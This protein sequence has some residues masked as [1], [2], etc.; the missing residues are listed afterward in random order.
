MVNI[1]YSS[2]YPV[3]LD[4][5]DYLS[6]LQ[7]SILRSKLT[8]KI[9]NIEDFIHTN[10]DLKYIIDLALKQI[11]D[12]KKVNKIMDKLSI[13]SHICIVSDFDTDGVSSAVTLEEC[14]TLLGYTNLS[15]V[16]NKRIYGTGVTTYCLDKIEE[17]NKTQPIDLIILSDHGSA[18]E[19]EYKIIKSTYKNIKIIL[20]DHHTIKQDN[21]PHSVDAFINPQ[22][23]KTDSLLKDLSGCAVAYL[24]MLVIAKDRY[25]IL[26]DT[27]YLVGLSTI[28]DIMPMDNII[29]RYF[30]KIGLNLLY[31]K[32]NSLLTK[33]LTSD[34]V[35][36][37]DL[38]FKVI[39]VINTGNRT[40]TEELSYNYLKGDE[41]SIASLEILNLERKKITSDICRN[42]EEE[43]RLNKPDKSICTIIDAEYSIA[44]NIAGKLGEQYNLPTIIF[45]QPNDEIITGSIRGILPMINVV[46]ILDDIK[47]QDDSILIRYGGHKSAG[48]CSIHYKKY[49]KFRDLFNSIVKSYLEGIDTTKTVYVDTELDDKDLHPGLMRSLD[50]IGPY[51]PNW[52]NPVFLTKLKIIHIIPIGSISK[53]LFRTSYNSTIE[54]VYHINKNKIEHLIGEKVDVVYNIEIYINRGTSKL[55]LFVLALKEL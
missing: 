53:I 10:I 44:G 4:N 7:K 30:V 20:T 52:D 54:G 24:T 13:T 15:T 11:P 31:T 5:I 39:P 29:N 36:P 19:A 26:Y 18:N 25:D 42:I 1:K 9:D 28:S 51:G 8:D 14:F 2:K 17:I 21:Y 48:G 50:I 55:S 41:G 45:N 46:Q 22:C 43:L 40:N 35:Y 16:I 33:T 23:I 12:M 27:M 47:Q 32:W 38:S 49:E 34:K 37:K 3:N 6:P